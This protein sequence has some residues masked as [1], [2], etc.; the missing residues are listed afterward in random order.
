MI[1]RD[2]SVPSEP[3]LVEASSRAGKEAALGAGASSAD[4]GDDHDLLAVGR[5]W[6]LG[7]QLRR[8]CQCVHLVNADDPNWFQTR[9]SQPTRRIASAMTVAWPSRK[10]SAGLANMPSMVVF[11]V[12]RMRARIVNAVLADLVPSHSFDAVEN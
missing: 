12:H 2:S 11:R 1:G 10:K 9:R 5:T 8:T 3:W 6:G 4:E 7:R